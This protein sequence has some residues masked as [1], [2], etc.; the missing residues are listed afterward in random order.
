MTEDEQ[1]KPIFSAEINIRTD[2]RRKSIRAGVAMEV[3]IDGNTFSRGIC[4]VIDISRFGARVLTYSPLE[5]KSSVGIALPGFLVRKAEVVWVS[6]LESGCQF[7]TPL[8][9][10]ELEELLARYGIKR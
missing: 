3:E 7:A 5:H 4:R 6:D 1:E 8:T 10:L 9:K 2:P